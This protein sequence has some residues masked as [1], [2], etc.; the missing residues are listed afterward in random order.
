MKLNTYAIIACAL[1]VLGLVWVI[2]AWTNVIN[3][4]LADWIGWIVMAVGGYFFQIYN[5]LESKNVS[6]FQLLVLVA[7]A[8]GEASAEELKQINEYGKLFDISGK[9]FEAI[10]KEA[11]EGKVQFPIPEEIDERKK[12]VKALIKMANADGQIDSKELALIK[13]VAKRYSLGEDYVESLI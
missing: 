6:L 11:T 2:L 1:M 5:S 4:P 12:N 3:F 8:D 7:C 10:V 13:E 9:R